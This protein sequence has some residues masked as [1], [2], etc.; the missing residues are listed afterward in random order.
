MCSA[1]EEDRIILEAHAIYG[2]KWALIAK[3]LPGRTDNAIKNHWNSALRRRC[4]DLRRSTPVSVQMLPNISTDWMKL[5]REE[6]QSGGALNSFKSLE[7]AERSMADHP[8]KPKNETLKA[9]ANCHLHKPNPVKSLRSSETEDS[10]LMEDQAKKYELTYAKQNPLSAETI[11]HSAEGRQTMVSRPVAKV[12]AFNVYNTSSHDSAFLGSVPMHGSLTQVSK[13]DSGI[14]KFLDSACGERMIPLRCGNGCCAASSGH[15]S[16][17]SLL[18]PE[19]VEYEELPSFSSQELA[20]VATD[21]NNIAWIRSG[22]ANSGMAS[23]DPSS[24]MRSE[25][26]SVCENMEDNVKKDKLLFDRGKLFTGMTRDVVT[27]QMTM[28]AFALQ[29]QVEGF[30]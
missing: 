3:I 22:L 18:G 2:N 9:T 17:G 25:G 30:S 21:L 4:V 1:D 16:Q 12:G 6:T 24:E 26:N 8:N 20:S 5:S 10:G 13:H 19:F 28:P 29:A 27:T 7:E 15:P 23:G 14:G 11:Y